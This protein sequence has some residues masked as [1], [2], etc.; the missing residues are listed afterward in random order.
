[1]RKNII[2]LFTLT[3]LYA[4][5]STSGIREP[6]GSSLQGH[7]RA[8]SMT[9][10]IAHG[11]FGE[12]INQSTL[13]PE[14]VCENC[15]HPEREKPYKIK[16]SKISDSQISALNRAFPKRCGYE[17]RA[18]KVSQSVRDMNC[19]VLKDIIYGKEL[20]IKDR[21]DPLCISSDCNI[22]TIMATAYLLRRQAEMAGP[23]SAK[24][25][26]WNKIKDDFR[27]PGKAYKQI[28]GNDGINMLTGP[29][30]YNFPN[31]KKIPKSKLNEQAALG[32]NGFPKPGDIMLFQRDEEHPIRNSAHASIF[33]HY[34]TDAS[35]NVEY[36]CA[37]SS[38][39]SIDKEKEGGFSIMCESI[40]HLSYIRSATIEL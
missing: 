5:N 37:W 19:E 15:D 16:P 25:E 32:A 2:Y 12:A 9:D 14:Q 29:D 34:K 1:V 6:V 27:C 21:S 24:M 40:K 7:S 11:R 33:S 22:A 39:S 4:C 38:F 26:R 17:Y 23:D 8:D 28:I 10:N 20:P 30:G 31:R 18:A 35:G 3:L 36:V 13:P